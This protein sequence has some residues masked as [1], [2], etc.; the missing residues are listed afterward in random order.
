MSDEEKAR[1]A[2]LIVCG[3]AKDTDEATE[4][5][6]MLGLLVDGALSVPRKP[7][8]ETRDI[9]DVSITGSPMRNGW[10]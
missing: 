6:E 3:E 7:L 2:T 10:N 8:L 4:L 9:R 5:L 1:K